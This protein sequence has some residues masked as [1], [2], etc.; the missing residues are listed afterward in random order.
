MDTAARVRPLTRSDPERLGAYR[1]V[2]RLGS[3]GMG[4]VYLAWDPAGGPVAI[5]LVHAALT[6][7]P[8]FAARFRSEVNRARQVPPFCT[9]EVL[10][11]DLDHQPPYVVFE[12]VDGPDLAEVVGT[13]GPLRAA[14]LQ[15]LAVGV[16]TALRGIHGAGVV[17]RDLKP[18]NVLLAPGSPKVIDFGI[19]HAFEPTSRHTRADDLVG[20]VAYMAPERFTDESGTA[21]VTAAADVFAWG[22]VVTYAGLGR[23]PFRG[24]SPAATAGRIL[25]QPPQL[26]GLPQPLRAVVARSLAKDPADRPTARELVDLLLDDRPTGLSAAPPAVPAGNAPPHEVAPVLGAGKAARRRLFVAA[27]AVALLGGATGTAIAMSRGDD[28]AATT[29]PATGPS[30]S[31]PGPAGG[32]ASGTSPSATA[33]PRQSARP[34]AANRPS[35]RPPGSAPAPGP[36]GARPA[37]SAPAGAASANPGGRNLALGRLASASSSE[38]DTWL[39]KFAVDGD[40]RS[41]WSSGFSDP[42]WLV[43]DLGARW[44]LTEIT[45]SWENAHAVAYRV[46]LSTDRKTWTSVYRTSAGQGGT[47]TIEAHQA[48]ARYVRVYC[49]ERSNQYGYSLY[50]VEVR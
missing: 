12:Y 48:V 3:G 39:P 22:C 13:R 31:S 1:L 15:S 27:V 2:G 9:A 32:P 23:T 18:E 50:E 33:A 14:A 35:T 10:D 46:Q 38:S 26:D 25:T 7:E 8:E 5:K 29:A 47:L 6:H 11:V 28:P 42:Q 36:T 43:V 40:A 20:T 21:G 49:T 41:R 34:P 24:D 19:A 16:A 4:I 37:G 30:G 45:L 17:H 44:R